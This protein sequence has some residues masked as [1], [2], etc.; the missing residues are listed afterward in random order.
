[1]YWLK[2]HIGHFR[3]FSFIWISRIGSQS[4]CQRQGRQVSALLCLRI[5]RSPWTPQ[6]LPLLT[7]WSLLL[8]S[9]IVA[10][11]AFYYA[12]TNY[13]LM[14]LMLEEQCNTGTI[15]QHN[16][17]RQQHKFVGVKTST[18]RVIV[19]V[20]F[21]RINHTAAATSS[22][23]PAVLYWA[24]RMAVSLVVN[25]PQKQ[26]RRRPINYW[27]TAAVNASIYTEFC[28]TFFP[29]HLSTELFTAY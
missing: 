5:I 22:F 7:S 12:T 4:I 3:C 1:M 27:N 25:I 9:V 2:R 29:H 26:W 13:F 17:S 6:K 19:I 8:A 14:M 10:I 18:R 28:N 16:W 23:V 20:N 15:S 21:W 24:L 11:H